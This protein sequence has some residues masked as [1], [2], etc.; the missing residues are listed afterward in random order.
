MIDAL[1]KLE[2]SREIPSLT[3]DKF[4]GNPLKYIEFIEKFK[5][6]IHDKKHL[7][8]NVRMMQLKMHLSGEAERVVSGLGS[9]GVMYASA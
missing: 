4:N 6:C 8:D 9:S 2:A 1:Y 3:I 7:S 5:S